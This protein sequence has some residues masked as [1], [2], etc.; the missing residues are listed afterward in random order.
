MFTNML[1]TADLYMDE[2]VN[3][4]DIDVSLS[5]AAWAICS[6]YHTV[7]KAS[8]GAAIFR[9]DKLFDIPIIVDWNKIGEHR[10]RLT[11]FNTTHENNGRINKVI[12]KWVRK[13]LYRKKVYSTKQNPD[14]RKAPGQLQQSIRKEQSC[15]NVETN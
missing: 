6:T 2:S 10:Q 9:P 4:S 14:G 11:D 12:T 3:A 5:D 15:F 1:R 8:L 13:Y 7:L